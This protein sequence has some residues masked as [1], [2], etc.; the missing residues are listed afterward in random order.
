MT[1]EERVK[2]YLKTVEPTIY[3]FICSKVERAYRA[4][5]QAGREELKAQIEELKVECV[6]CGKQFVI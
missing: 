2:K 5:L 1:D 6:V 4:G 3:D